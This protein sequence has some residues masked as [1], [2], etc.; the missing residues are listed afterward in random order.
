MEAEMNQLEKDIDL[1]EKHTS[2][3]IA[4]TGMAY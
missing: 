2:I 4:S 3:Y 1:L